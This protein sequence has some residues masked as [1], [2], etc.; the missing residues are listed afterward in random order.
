MP[1]HMLD[2]APVGLVVSPPPVSRGSSSFLTAVPGV[3]PPDGGPFAAAAREHPSPVA[4][5]RGWLRRV[6]SVDGTPWLSPLLVA[7]LRFVAP[8][9]PATLQTGRRRRVAAGCLC[10]SSQWFF[11]AKALRLCCTDQAL[12]R[13]LPPEGTNVRD[14]SILQRSQGVA[15]DRSSSRRPVSLASWC[16]PLCPL[17]TSGWQASWRCRPLSPQRS[18]GPACAGCWEGAGQP[19]GFTTLTTHHLFSTSKNNS[20]EV[21][22]RCHRQSTRQ[23]ENPNAGPVPTFLARLQGV[24]DDLYGHCGSRVMLTSPRPRESTH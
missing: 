17:P 10:H 24:L 19:D 8:L 7:P 5:S 2:V 20:K 22:S 6:E 4:R 15:P 16:P 21:F 23:S 1:A 9:S 18:L 14:C 11:L 12:S 3:V 13:L